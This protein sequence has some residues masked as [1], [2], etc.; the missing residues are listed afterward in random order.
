MPKA[1]INVTEKEIT[2]TTIDCH[3]AHSKCFVKS[4]PPKAFV[5]PLLSI[6][7]HGVKHII[8]NVLTLPGRKVI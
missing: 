2:D 4:F 6:T 5:L 7:G 1:P 3:A 8:S